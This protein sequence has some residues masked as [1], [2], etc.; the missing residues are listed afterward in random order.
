MLVHSFTSS[1]LNW[2]E[3]IIEKQKYLMTF[4][5]QAVRQISQFVGFD[6]QLSEVLE[7]A[8][9]AFILMGGGL[10]FGFA[11]NILLA[12]LLG[13]E[14]IG[15]YFLAFDI[16]SI[17]I[18]LATLGLN[19]TVL[20]FT[21]AYA[22]L[23]DWSSVR[24]VYRT[25]VWIVAGLSI[26]STIVLI[27]LA[28]LI[29]FRFYSESRLVEPLRVMS[30]VILPTALLSLNTEAL[31]GLKQIR[32][33]VFLST[34]GI[35][36]LSLPLIM[37]FVDW[38][39][40]SGAIVARLVAS[41]A[42][43]LLGVFLWRRTVSR[44]HEF[45]SAFPTHH[46]LKTSFPFL[47]VDFTNL[48][49]RRADTVLLGIWA[50]TE[51]VG[52]YNAAIRMAVLT[53]FAL[54]AVNSII[55]PKFAALYAQENKVAL[56]KLTRGITRL[57][58]LI[59]IMITVPLFLFSPFLVQ[60]YGTEFLRGATVL[61]ILLVGQFVNVAAGPVG[62]LLLMTGHEKVQQNNVLANA[63][64]NVILN[65]LLIPRYGLIGAAV[66]SSISLALKNLISVL[67]VYRFMAIRV[68]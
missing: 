48:M 65:I 5:S 35:P 28:P 21:A 39:G 7:K 57:M 8:G 49:M 2:Y 60:M 64:L 20:R 10:G 15:I 18:T 50:T 43:L 16:S 63:G 13:A 19:K 52:I 34:V 22:S 45:K 59:G 62:F 51:D 44:Y 4:I 46:L 30:L 6:N 42:I 11:V 25:S 26:C 41:V 32:N 40:L 33:S 53:S 3:V 68:W 31:R 29:A 24:G 66:A 37:I 56:E 1:I 54:G 61:R 27:A 23:G 14:G 47:S 67:L 17:A 38:L 58:V 12:R 55:A 36:L 9:M